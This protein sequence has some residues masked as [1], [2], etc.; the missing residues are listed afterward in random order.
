MRHILLSEA[1]TP[2]ALRV[3]KASM[4]ARLVAPARLAHALTPGRP[5]AI[6]SAIN[7]P[8]ITVTANQY[9]YTAPR[10]HKDPSC[11]FHRRPTSRQS[12]IDRD[13]GFVEYSTPHPR[14]ARCGARQRCELGGLGRC[15]AC[16]S[17]QRLFYLIPT[18][19]SG[20]LANPVPSTQ[21]TF[22]GFTFPPSGPYLLPPY[23][24][25]FVPPFTLN[26]MED[27]VG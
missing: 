17:W 26:E 23:L 1:V 3:R 24:R 4:P 16:S 7:L 27:K 18:Y 15:R 9:L 22:S 5:R 21:P 12:D 11:R 25:R 8:A 20:A 14:T 10:T 19:L 6:P 13:T 2:T